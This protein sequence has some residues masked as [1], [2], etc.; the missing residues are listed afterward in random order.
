[1]VTPEQRAAMYGW[2][3]PDPRMRANV[4]IRRRLAPLLDNSPPRD[5]AHPR[6]RAL[7]ARARRASTTA[8]RSAWAT[9]SGS[10]TV[11]PCAPRCSGPPTA[12]PASPAADPGKLY[13]PVISS[14]VYHYNGVNVEA[15]MATGHSLLHWL[16]GM[17][18]VRRLHPAFGLGD[19]TIAPTDNESILAYTRSWGGDRDHPGETLLCINNLS[20]KPQAGD[21][22]SCP[23]S[24][25]S[26]SCS[27]SSAARASRGSPPTAG[28]PSRWAA[29]TS[30]G[31]GSVRRRR[32]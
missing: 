13:L 31:C 12:T 15:Q 20:D 24:W 19:F 7:A 11:T 14:L 9:T 32:G 1:M 10:T 16:R 28:S 22:R 2:Y 26:A 3:A 6:A 21:D 8:T 27:T 17:L 30:S 4:G 18:D 29:A 25:A 23:R 5:R